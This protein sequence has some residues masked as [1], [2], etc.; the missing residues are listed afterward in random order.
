MSVLSDLPVVL[1]AG[2]AGGIPLGAALAWSDRQRQ[3]RARRDEA[4][5]S[6]ASYGLG[7]PGT[8]DLSG[9]YFM[10]RPGF[11][12]RWMAFAKRE[13]FVAGG[14][15]Y[16]PGEVWFEYG[17]TEEEALARIETEVR[18]LASEAVTGGA[19]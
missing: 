11:A 3:A 16:E 9:W 6:W 4:R 17:A 14:S 5:A 10:V 2:I 19:A 8:G 12:R 13:P 1:L 7:T 18:A 15:T